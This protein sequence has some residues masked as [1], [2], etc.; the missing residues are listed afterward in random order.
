MPRTSPV[1]RVQ[2]R[3]FNTIFTVLVSLLSLSAVLSADAKSVVAH[4]TGSITS[5]S[6]CTP[7]NPT[8]ICQVSNVS[9]VA[10]RLG[11]LTGV[12]NERVDTTTGRYEGT[13]VFM[14][15]NGATISTMFVGHVVPNPD[16][17]AVFEEGHVITGGTG[18]Y[19]DTT[20]DLHVVGTAAVDLSLVID[21][22]GAISR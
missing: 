10:T 11:A 7:N 15:S 17:S 3:R 18:K 5:R 21:G 9:G 14:L 20:G 19:A 4:A 2:V 16:G 22:V 1:A 13:A 12:L 6:L 8:L